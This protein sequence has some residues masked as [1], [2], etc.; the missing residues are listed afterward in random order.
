LRAPQTS[1]TVHARRIFVKSAVQL[2]WEDIFCTR[3]ELILLWS[4]ALHGR[5]KL[6]GP[7]SHSEGTWF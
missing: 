2:E 3:L 6:L 7:D 1:I 5:T 4:V